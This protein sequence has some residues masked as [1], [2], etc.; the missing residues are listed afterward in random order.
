MSVQV[1]PSA[2]NVFV[3]HAFPE[4]QADL[5]EVVLNYAEAGTPDKPA[6]LLLP[7][8]TGSWWS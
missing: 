2:R 7:E 4:Q 8:Q 5:G 3:P 6:L 1:T